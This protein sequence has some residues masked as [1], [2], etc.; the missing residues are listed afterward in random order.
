MGGVFN[1][2]VEADGTTDLLA[3]ALSPDMMCEGY[4]AFLQTRRHVKTDGQ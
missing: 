1:I 3:Y 4:I 2:S